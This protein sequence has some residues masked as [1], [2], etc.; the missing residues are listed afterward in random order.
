MQ[1]L[2]FWLCAGGLR[3]RALIASD[4]AL[5]VISDWTVEEGLTLASLIIA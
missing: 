3:K 2:R 1:S 5:T 4:D